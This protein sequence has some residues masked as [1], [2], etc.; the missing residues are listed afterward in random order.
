MRVISFFFFLISWTTLFSQVENP[1][2]QKKI[3][4]LLSESIPTISVQ[5]LKNVK[6]DFLLLDI[7]EWEE[8]EISRIPEALH[9]GFKNPKFEI[10]SDVSKDQEIVVYCSIGYRSEKI[11]ERLKAQG[12]KN[13]RNLYGSIFEWA[14]QGF[15]MENLRGNITTELHTYNRKWSKWVENQDVQ[16][17]Y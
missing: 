11:G 3:D 8:Y 7:R 12:F 2:F 14:N 17:I 9:F 1:K 5:E 6:T 15:P 16:K 4:R 10:L 13:V